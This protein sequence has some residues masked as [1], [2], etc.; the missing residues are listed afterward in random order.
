MQI[1]DCVHRCNTRLH[2]G[3]RWSALLLI[4]LALL[5]CVQS[6]WLSGKAMLAQHLL[7]SAWRN[8]LAINE[9]VKPWPWSD[10]F[11]V[12]KLFIP[13]LDR[14]YIV[15]SDASGESM[16][17]GPGL[18]SGNINHAATE[19]VAIGG[20]RDTHLAMLEQLPIGSEI[21]LQTHTGQWQWYLLTE[22]TIVDSRHHTVAINTANPGLVLITCYPFN[23]AQTGGP[24]RYVAAAE[25]LPTPL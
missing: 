3:A 10:T 12:A 24:L 13:S 9:P 7:N 4:T 18:V 11:P 14:S 22:L 15:L 8:T 23:A 2:S 5:L 20:H 17:F 21:H 16:A 1:A 6:F 19:V 25:L